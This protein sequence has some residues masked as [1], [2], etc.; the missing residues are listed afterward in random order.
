MMVGIE[1]G[2]RLDQLRIAGEVRAREVAVLRAPDAMQLQADL[3]AR[4]L[5]G[6]VVGQQ[7]VVGVAAI[8]AV[9]HDL[10]I[11][12]DGLCVLQ[13]LCARAR[14]PACRW[15]RTARTRRWSSP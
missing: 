11:L 13:R 7:P 5:A 1:V 4:D 6:V 3:E 8:V 2:L 10:H 9:E 14:T 12:I 15:D